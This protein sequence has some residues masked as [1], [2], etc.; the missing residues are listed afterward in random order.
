MEEYRITWR[1]E[2]YVLAENDKEAKEAWENVKLGSLEDEEHGFVEMN[3]FEC[4][5]DDYRDVE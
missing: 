1:H 4:V 2:V 3:S 5:S